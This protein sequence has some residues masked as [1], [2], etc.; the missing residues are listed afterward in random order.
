MER[1]PNVQPWHPSIRLAEY[2]NTGADVCV[3]CNKPLSGSYYRLNGKLACDACVQRVKMRSPRD[4]HAAFVRAILF[5]IGGAILGLIIYSAFAILT[6]IVIGYVALAVGWLVATAMKKGSQGVSGR[7]HQIAAV[8]LTYAA[9]S[10]S[11]I[12]IGISFY[13]KEKK[14]VAHATA[15]PK[16]SAST[17]PDPADPSSSSSPLSGG[18]KSAD[19][20]QPVAKP[21][22]G[23]IIASML[24]AGLASPFLEL[25][26]GVS[27]ILGLV[28][29]FVGIRIAWK[30]TSAPPLEILGPFQASA[31]TATSAASSS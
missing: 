25:Q 16:S 1:R 20:P 10:L 21:A 5:G 26:S 4:S 3:G 9:V 14:P 24:F 12:P 11:A 27:G 8:A 17:S 2:K 28:I 18:P 22:V 30:I 23:A 19:S 6:G 15:A 29:L 7:R 31:P 13:L